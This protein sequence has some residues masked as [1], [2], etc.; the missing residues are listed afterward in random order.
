MS[1]TNDP[2]PTPR[3]IH[4]A[5]RV[6]RAIRQELH[7]LARE[8]VGFAEILSALGAMTA[9]LITASA[10]PQ[11]IAPWFERWARCAREQ[12]DRRH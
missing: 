9:E 8:G 10:G 6:Q 5:E 4:D 3:Q 7:L 12:E 11:F 1:S 2:Q